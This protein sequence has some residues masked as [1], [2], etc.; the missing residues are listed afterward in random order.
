[1]FP[2]KESFSNLVN[3]ESLYGTKAPFFDL[4]E[5]ILIQL[6]KASKDLFILAPSCN[7]NPLF[8]V[9]AA[10]S[11]PAKSTKL[12][13]LVIIVALLFEIF[14]LDS[15]SYTLFMIVCSI[16]KVIIAWDLELN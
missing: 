8:S 2:P 4:S 9:T 5:R 15:P 10:L 1:M 14:S 7:L 11:E 16:L 12:N 13:L 6:P 3:L